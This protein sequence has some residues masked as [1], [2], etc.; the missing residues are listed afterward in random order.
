MNLSIGTAVAVAFVLTSLDAFALDT[1]EEIT[2]SDLPYDYLVYSVTWQPS[3]CKLKPDTPGCEKPP[4]RFLTHGIW[5]YN[6][7][8]AQKT[9]RHPAFCNT[10]PT[11][12]QRAEC[13]LSEKALKDIVEIPE[14]A[15]RVTVN[16]QGMFKHEWSKHGTCSGKSEYAYFAD[17]DKLWKVVNYNDPVFKQWIGSS[18]DFDTLKNVFPTN[19]TFRCFVQSDRQYLHEVFYQIYPDGKPYL[20]DP[21]LQIGIPCQS[22]ETFIPG[23]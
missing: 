17:I 1:N 16:P 5:P 18:V 11:C 9:N 12:Q 6:N 13:G 19:V 2:P 20:E 14:I 3:F 7:S 4:V 21:D 8:T 22:R 15:Q 23:A 10:A